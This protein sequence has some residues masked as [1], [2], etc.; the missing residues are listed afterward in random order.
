MNKVELAKDVLER[1]ESNFFTPMVGQYF[2][3]KSGENLYNLSIT[4][5]QLLEDGC[6]VCAVGAFVVSQLL[7]DSTDEEVF[8]FASFGSHPFVNVMSDAK[9]DDLVFAYDGMPGFKD[10]FHA[11]PDDKERMKAMCHNIVRNG[12]FA[13]EDLPEPQP[14]PE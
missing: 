8:T 3:T 13:Y 4:R 10:W 6:Q 12:Y 7:Q 11:Y 9:F 1:L 2:K 14:T 5:E